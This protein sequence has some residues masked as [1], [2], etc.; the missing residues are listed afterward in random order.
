M[1][2]IRVL[3]IFLISSSSVFAGVCSTEN[4][5]SRSEVYSAQEC[6][7]QE[8][9]KSINIAKRYERFNND[10][11]VALKNFTIIR[12]K[13]KKYEIITSH[14]SDEVYLSKKYK[15][16]NLM[17]RSKIELREVESRSAVLDNLYLE[18]KKQIVMLRDELELIELN[19]EMNIK[20]K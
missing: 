12:A 7:K 1:S 8:I 18:F 14:D 5:T 4:I 10:V 17:N 2:I 20:G 13:C 19:Y 3:S 6:L 16:C 9:E 15:Y 11:L